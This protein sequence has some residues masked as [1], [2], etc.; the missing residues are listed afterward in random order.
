MKTGSIYFLSIPLLTLLIGSCVT[1]SSFQQR[2]GVGG[3]LSFQTAFKSVHSP[4]AQAKMAVIMTDTCNGPHYKIVESGQVA[5][6][7]SSE[8]SSTENQSG[9]RSTSF[10]SMFSN[11]V[12]TI[13]GGQSTH[14]SSSTTTAK[15]YVYRVNYC[16]TD[17][18][19]NCIH[20][21]KGASYGL[22]N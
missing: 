10:G 17:K 21:D 13:E 22:G 3:I 16:C 5:I 9:R 14:G 8:T 7:S 6:G 1:V 18:N 19:G 4:A 20:K 11:E 12:N 2:P 15:D